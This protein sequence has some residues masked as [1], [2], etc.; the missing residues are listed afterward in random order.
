[1]HMSR[2]DLRDLSV[3]ILFGVVAAPLWA[4]M[5]GFLSAFTQLPLLASLAR[6]FGSGIKPWV[7]TYMLAWEV[8]GGAVCALVI[9]LPLGYLLRRH[10]LAMWLLFALLFLAIFAWPSSYI[11]DAEPQ[12]FALSYPGPWVFL[13]WSALFVRVGHRLRRQSLVA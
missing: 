13:A 5:I 1:M 3:A 9:A 2:P 10:V 4:G 7:P 12:F 11:D 6:E 8:V